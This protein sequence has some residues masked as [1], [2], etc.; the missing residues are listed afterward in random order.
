MP[1]E[2][3][4]EPA[5]PDRLKAYDFT[6]A[7]ANCCDVALVDKSGLRRFPDQIGGGHPHQVL[8]G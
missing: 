4:T 8:A 6:A 5:A 1:G 7:S 2:L 3:E